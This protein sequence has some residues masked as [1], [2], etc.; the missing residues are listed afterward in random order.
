MIAAS[1]VI[2]YKEWVGKAIA[3]GLFWLV[4]KMILSRLGRSQDKCNEVVVCSDQKITMESI[5]AAQFGLKNIHEMM[6]LSNISILKILSIIH[7]KARKQ[8]DMVM[9]AMTVLAIIFAVVPLKYML[10]A[11]TLHSFIMTSKLG[12][13]IGN[14]QGNRRLKRMVGFDPNCPRSGCRRRFSMPAKPVIVCLKPWLAIYA[15]AISTRNAPWICVCYSSW[16][17]NV[18]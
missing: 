8:A 6:Q 4:L 12:R 9:V 13:H 5:V 1:L 17:P 11:I 18:A 15:A 3:A 2:I 14:A 7:A 16:Q 10:I